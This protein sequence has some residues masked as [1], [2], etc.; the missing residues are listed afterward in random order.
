MKVANMSGK[1][2]EAIAR[3][4]VQEG[5]GR[6]RINGKLLE[7]FTGNRIAQLRIKEPLII[8]GDLAK[9]T[10]IAVNVHGGGFKA[11]ADAIRLS[12]A[13]ALVKFSGSAPLKKQFLAYDRQM[14]VADVRRKETRKPNDSKA[15]A[16]R[17]TSYR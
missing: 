9:K 3:A 16:K 12:I 6:L 8:A 15:R 13:K 5:K 7:A 4:T 10:D 1:R 11:Q 17:Q 14:M 2:K